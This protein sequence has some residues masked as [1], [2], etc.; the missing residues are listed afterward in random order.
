MFGNTNLHPLVHI[1]VD[2]YGS[3]ELIHGPAIS[4]VNG[5]FFLVRITHR[6]SGDVFAAGELACD[7]PGQLQ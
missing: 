6:H 4:L 3:P 7:K 2:I 1:L 5:D